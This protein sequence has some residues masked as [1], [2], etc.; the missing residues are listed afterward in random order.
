MPGRRNSRSRP[1]GGAFSVGHLMIASPFRPE[2]LARLFR[3]HPPAGER[4]R[5]LEALAGDR[6]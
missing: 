3:T 4:V 2:G 5:R 6:R 1:T